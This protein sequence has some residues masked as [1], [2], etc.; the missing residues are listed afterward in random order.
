MKEITEQTLE[1]DLR[2]VTM[3]AGFSDQKSKCTEKSEKVISKPK[4]P[5]NQQASRQPSTHRSGTRF[6][7]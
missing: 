1:P 6:A 3:L 7:G 4:M 2:F 5:L